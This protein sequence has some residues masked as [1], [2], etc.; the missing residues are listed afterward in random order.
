MY[1]TCVDSIELIYELYDKN[2]S[3]T[4][5]IFIFNNEVKIN[6]GENHKYDEL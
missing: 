6:I 5:C 4:V 1:G 2:T 3:I